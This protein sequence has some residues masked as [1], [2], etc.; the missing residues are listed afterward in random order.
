M[1]VLILQAQDTPD[2]SLFSYPI[3]DVPEEEEASSAQ[4]AKISD[5]IKVKLQEILLLL[6]QDIGQL[7]QDAEP[8]RNILK[9]LRNQLPESVEDALIPAAFIESQQP[10]ISKAQKRLADHSKQERIVKEKEQFMTHAEAT[11][12][13][14]GVLNR[15][16]ARI[17]KSI[18][19]LKV[20]REILLK[21][22]EEVNRAIIEEKSCLHRLPL[23][24]QQ[25]KREKQEYSRQA[26]RLHKS[27][28]PIP[29]STDED[30]KEIQEVDQIRLRAMNAIQ[31]LLDSL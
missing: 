3:G 22:L 25:L 24:I 9:G 12:N 4:S 29:G 23:D 21:E 2:N 20:K 27:I 17:Q 8:I 6:N 26:Y 19:D 1:L 7:V 13:Q 30:Q 5:P 15:C 18:Q 31:N 10:R 28:Q 16:Q 14:I 11:R